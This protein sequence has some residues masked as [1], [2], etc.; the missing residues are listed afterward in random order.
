[1]FGNSPEQPGQDKCK[2]FGNAESLK[3]TLKN[4]KKTV[5]ISKEG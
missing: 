5:D 3:K 2:M 1:M 4:F